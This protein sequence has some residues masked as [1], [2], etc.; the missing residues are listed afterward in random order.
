MITVYT[1]T[2]CSACKRTKAMF[3]NRGVEYETVDITHDLELIDALRD[4][5]YSEMP[6]VK[7][8]NGESWQ[9]FKPGLIL[10]VA[11]GG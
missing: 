7:L 5:G 11:N 9:G 8:P 6:V 3:D 4:E 10:G 1:K 2:N